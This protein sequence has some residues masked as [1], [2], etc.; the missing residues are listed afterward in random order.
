MT[1]AWQAAT[2]GQATLVGHVNQL[3][4]THAALFTY[5]GAVINTDP[6]LIDDATSLGAG[7]L[8][9]QVV[10]SE[11]A[12][13]GS[14]LVALGA[15]GAGQDVLVTLQADS[16]GS[17]SG[18]PLVGCVVPPEW[19]VTGVADGPS[20]F[21]VPL[22]SSL[23]AGTYWVVLQ[24]GSNLLGGADEFVQAFAGVN[25]VQ[26]TRTTSTGG[27]VYSGGNWTDESYGFGL[28]L[29]DDT[30][31]LLT[32]IAD[33]QIADLSYYVPAKVTSYGYSDGLL[34]EAYEWVV[35]SLGLNP[36]LLCRDDASFEITIGTATE[37]ANATVS[38]SDAVA[39]EGQYSLEMVP[40][41]S[42]DMSAQVGP[43]PVTA[44]DL[45]TATAGFIAGTAPAFALVAIAW[46]DGD[47]LL[48]TSD[49]ASAPV[50]TSGWNVQ[51]VTDTAPAS[52]TQAYVQ[53]A[54]TG[55]TATDDY[56]ADA[57]GMFPGP[58][59]VWSY[60]GVG[61]ASMRTLSYVDGE[62]VSA[63]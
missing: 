15:L 19:L 27:A 12:N 16:A 54:F 56:Y 21:T 18:T 50:G 57:A 48:S 14:V 6:T 20:N 9:Q 2:S 26:W 51:T 47:T 3:L 32:T 17:P 38:Q 25:D 1:G 37:V 22:A 4:T 63:S 39:L 30:G 35:R 23:A 43:Y 55:T 29:R 33:D 11:P 62:L 49:G 53:F 8:A 7:M 45:Y 46:Y 5:N 61:I 34:T 10:L 24:P 40:T 28:Y 42:G 41:S 58:A 13:L 44:G 59:A 36:N 52:A 60:P 31:T